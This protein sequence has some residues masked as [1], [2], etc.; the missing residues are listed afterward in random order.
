[1]STNLVSMVDQWLFMVI[2]GYQWL[3]VVINGYGWLSMVIHGFQWL[4]MV[5]SVVHGYQWLYM[6]INGYE[7]LWLSMVMDGYIHNIIHDAKEQI[8]SFALCILLY[9]ME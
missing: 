1:M 5:I 8:H 4:Y 7:R 9:T 2:S 6:V 3:S